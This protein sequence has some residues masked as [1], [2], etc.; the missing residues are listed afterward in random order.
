VLS[1]AL[2]NLLLPFPL[3]QA[4]ARR[5]ARGEARLPLAIAPAAALGY[6]PWSI[7]VAGD[8]RSP[9]PDRLIDVC[10][11]VLAPSAALVCHTTPGTR[12]RAPLALAVA[13]T[14]DDPGLGELPGAR[15]QAGA[16]PSTIRVLGGRHWSPKSATLTQLEQELRAIGPDA[17]VAFMCHAVRGSAD[18][19]SKGGIV[20][21]PDEQGTA[22]DRYDIL[23]P[24]AVFAMNKRGLT[25]PSQVILQ[26]CDTSALKDAASGE[27]LTIAPAFISAGTREVVTTVYPLIDLPGV[28]DPVTRAALRGDS[29]QAAVA[30]MQREGLTRWTS[31]HHPEPANT[32]FAWGAYATVAVQP[33]T[34]TGASTAPLAR[35][36]ISASFMRVLANAVGTCQQTRVKCL[37]SGYILGELLEDGSLCEGLDGG[38]NSMRPISFA[39]T[40]GPYICTR[41]LHIRDRGPTTPLRVN[42]KTINVPYSVI[43]AIRAGRAVADRDGLPLTSHHVV[44]AMLSE[45]TAARRIV[46]FLTILTRKRPALIH[47]AI[48]WELTEEISGRLTA[49]SKPVW[50]GK[51]HDVV[52][53]LLAHTFPETSALNGDSG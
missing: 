14:T 23:T 48:E 37:D 15:A 46:T 36:T 16:L 17:T 6:I 39:W 1:A 45:S 9:D 52:E 40:V 22:G 32:P 11:W 30:R 4:A 26:A 50:S 44:T 20:L 31:G 21:A 27:W 34:R 10:D 47:R 41:Y 38:G 51:H 2:G 43:D 19:P 18:E 35:P 5:R 28:D 13:D 12:T 33:N 7:L 53:S 24:Q 42:G 25:M 8:H 49:W 3:V 29:L